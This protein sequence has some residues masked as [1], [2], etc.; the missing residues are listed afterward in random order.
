MSGPFYGKYRGVVTSTKD[1]LMIGRIQARVPDVMGDDASG[2]AM[3][4]VP[5]AGTGMGWFALP[6]DGSGVW[7]EFEH[8]DPD[9]PIW[10]G[11]WWGDATEVPSQVLTPPQT[12]KVLLR[13]DG[14]SSILIDDT[15]GVGGITLA[16]AAGQ[17][18]VISATGIEIDNG[19]GASLKMQGPQVS[20]NGG[21]LEV[22]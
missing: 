14:G 18:V 2:W 17:K 11:C 15:P 22:T 1:P 6:A 21:A 12:G 3:P 20:V 16:T 19:S 4:C 10:T 9:Y 8:G 13:T 7:I 5:F